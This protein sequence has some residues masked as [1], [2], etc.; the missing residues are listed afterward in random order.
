MQVSIPSEMCVCKICLMLSD[1]TICLRLFAVL[2]FIELSLKQCFVLP[3]AG[4]KCIREDVTR[5]LVIKNLFD[6]HHVWTLSI[7]SYIYS[8]L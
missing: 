2:D 4:I 3:L 5:M 1:Q 6:A 8:S 7:S